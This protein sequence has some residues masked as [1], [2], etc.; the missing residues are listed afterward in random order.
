MA[1]H[2]KTPSLVIILVSKTT[3]GTY[4]L[5]LDS[6]SLFDSVWM[7]ANRTELK[8]TLNCNCTATVTAHLV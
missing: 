2:L 8:W 1:R 7:C 5:Y 3:L 6:L 4:F